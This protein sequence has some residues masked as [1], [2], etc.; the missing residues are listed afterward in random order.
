MQQF[1]RAFALVTFFSFAA[2]AFAADYATPDEAVSM[3]KKVI[4][5]IKANGKEKAIAEVNSQKQFI[6]RDLYVSIGD[7]HGMSL[8]HG[9][10][11]KMVGKNLMELKD[12]EG[13][14]F[15]RES[16]ESLKT[17]SSSWI[18]YKWP[19]PVTR[20]IESKSMYSEKVD[21]V[22]VSVGAYKH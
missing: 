2:P 16:N 3:V 13:K 22:V 1:L 4:A 15:V 7:M 11:P 14:P 17:K 6:D 9:G 10:N 20:Q 12:V 5:Y 19:N 21:D 18:D 8:A